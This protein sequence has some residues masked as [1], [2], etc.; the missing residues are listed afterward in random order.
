MSDSL[1]SL[2][3]LFDREDVFILEQSPQ[4]WLDWL[5][6]IPSSLTGLLAVKLFEKRRKK[7]V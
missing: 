2:D 1:K 7:S 4:M 6:K 3:T 5:T